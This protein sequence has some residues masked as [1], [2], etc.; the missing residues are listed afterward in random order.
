MATFY[1]VQAASPGRTYVV[2]SG[3]TY[4]ADINGFIVGVLTPQDLTD[5]VAAGCVALLPSP[6]N[7]I[8]RL[9]GANFNVTTDQQ[10]VFLNTWQKY[11][12]TKIAVVNTS[13][14]GMSTAEGGFY[15]GGGKSGSII[16]QASQVYTGLTNANTA[17]NLT[18]NQPDLI[19]NAA[20]PLFLSLS[21]PQG[22]AAFAD[23]Y[24]YG[25][26]YTQ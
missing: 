5:L 22:A 19:L 3:T 10:I 17:L 11:R 13:V 25:D 8:G 6:L 18:L 24:V 20:T 26:A 9:L 14:A 12:I 1:A 16:V 4:M 21:T 2:S 15:T 7:N 23:I